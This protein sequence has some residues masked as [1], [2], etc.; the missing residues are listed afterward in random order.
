ML[1]SVHMHVAATQFGDRGA[2]ERFLS[3]ALLLRR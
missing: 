1:D 3:L 2:L